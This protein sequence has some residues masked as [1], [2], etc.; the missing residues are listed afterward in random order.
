MLLDKRLHI[1]ITLSGKTPLYRRF[2]GWLDESTDQISWRQQ[3]PEWLVCVTIVR[4][5][6]FL[7]LGPNAR[8][9]LTVEE[10]SRR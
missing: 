10:V 5:V 3:L 9:D 2:W 6:K 8:V 7:K 1:R 4:K